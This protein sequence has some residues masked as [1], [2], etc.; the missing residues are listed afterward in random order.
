MAQ[1]TATLGP[2]LFLAFTLAA[3]PA[4]G[5]SI[6]GR[7]ADLA[8]VMA[9]Q[10]PI[11]ENDKLTLT[12]VSA[13]GERMIMKHSV[14]GPMKDFPDLARAD[15]VIREICSEANGMTAFV[16]DGGSIEHVFVFTDRSSSVVLTAANCHPKVKAL[17]RADLQDLVGTV[18]LPMQITE[19][20]SI[21]GLHVGDGMELVY[22]MADSSM[23]PEEAKRMTASARA[24]IEARDVAGQCGTGGSRTFVQGGATIV[25]RRKAGDVTFSEARVDKKACGLK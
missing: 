7:A 19:K 9:T 10:L 12:E 24:G 21:V 8:R 14:A 13:K 3:L 20:L 22:V 6:A 18:K 5:A 11:K 16:T 4:S 25:V 17:T 2:L 15:A 1:P 23:S